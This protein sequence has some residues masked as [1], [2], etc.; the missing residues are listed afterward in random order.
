MN[1][2][3]TEQSKSNIDLCDLLHFEYN[4]SLSTLVNVGVAVYENA[5]C[6]HITMYN[7]KA[8]QSSSLV[9]VGGEVM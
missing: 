2:H 3:L 1:N 8:E 9:S 5:Q 4:A 6:T 7:V